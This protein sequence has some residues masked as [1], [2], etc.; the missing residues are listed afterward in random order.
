MKNIQ[1][2]AVIPIALLLVLTALTPRTARATTDAYTAGFYTRGAYTG[3]Y[4]DSG[5]PIYDPIYVPMNR[6]SLVPR[7]TLTASRE[8]NLFMSS[9]RQSATVIYLI[10]G[11]TLIWG[12]PE[13]NHLFADAGAI[14]PLED[15]SGQL[16]EEPSLLLS[17]GG[18]YQ[19]GKSQ[20]GAQAAYRR[21]ENVDT[22][23]GARIVKQDYIANVVVD[24][25][26]SAK[27]T[28]GALGS[29]ERHDFEAAEFVDYDRI[30]GAARLYHELTPLSQVFVQGGIGRDDL[31]SGP[32]GYGDADFYDIS[33]GLRGKLSPKSSASG[34]VGYQWRT[35][36]DDA[37]EDVEHWIAS[38]YAETNPFGF[39]TFSTELFAD[40][41]PAIHSVGSS[42]IDQRWTGSVSRR[43][44]VDRLRGQGSVYVG[45]IDYR[46]PRDEPRLQEPDYSLV[47]DR[48]RD[49]YWG[50]TLGL[51][52]WIRRNF[53]CGLAYAYIENEAARDADEEVRR[54][55]S[56]DS[57]R[58]TLRLSWNY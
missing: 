14:I 18:V 39:T 19:T 56:Y 49:E 20:V 41:R 37:L 54:A 42:A 34:R 6:W 22:L 53:S 55:G 2:S 13:A 8:D 26:T 44:F 29:F 40:I 50:F 35:H 7:V 10:P 15:S 28:V 27:S 16:E 46:S 4:L 57:G 3:Y 21:L 47:Y 12:R 11:A 58:W 52:W 25:H 30:Y 23:V 32:G 24:H 38:L 43:L 9:E 51:D 31:D 17:L 33:L 36:D 1:R 45:R 48:R 5:D